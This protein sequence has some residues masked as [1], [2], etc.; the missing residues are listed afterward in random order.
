MSEAASMSVTILAWR[1]IRHP[2]AGGSERY[3]HEMARRLATAGH[4]VRIITARTTGAARREWIDGVLHVRRGGRLSVYAFGMGYLALHRRQADVVVDVMNGMPFF[5][6]LLAPGRVV[7]LLHHIHDLQWRTVFPGVRGRI[8]SALETAA[9]PR[10]YR[11]RPIVTVSEHTRRRLIGLGLTNE[12]IVVVR[13]GLTSATS[14]ASASRSPR[15]RVVV[16][17]RLVSHKRIHQAIDLVQ[18]LRLLGTEV[19]VDIVGDGFLRGALE[20]HARRVGVHSDITFHGHVP[21]TRRDEILAA[22]WVLILP[23]AMEGW[24][25]VILEAARLGTPSIAYRYAGGVTEAILDGTTG[26]L[27]DDF[28]DFVT[29][30]HEAVTD[31]RERTA[32]GRAA[33]DWAA[34]YDW[35]LSADAF[36]KVLQATVSGRR[37]R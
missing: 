19:A 12:Q 3:V 35:D 37:R 31:D 29:I 17:A 24:G 7:G 4:S 25:L 20:E 5:A 27:A 11:K 13:N 26:W 16:V 28:E 30:V 36:T 22:A 10:L 32:R 1:D 33:I 8:G 34:G 9:M 21:D 15:P 14:P 23:S 18:R 2:E 6:V